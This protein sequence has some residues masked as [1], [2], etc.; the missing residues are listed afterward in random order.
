MEIEEIDV[1]IDK[2]EREIQQ[3]LDIKRRVMRHKLMSNN[4]KKKKL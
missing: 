3:A 4:A 2:A 1:L